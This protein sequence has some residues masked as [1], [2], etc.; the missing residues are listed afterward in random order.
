VSADDA[1]A[2]LWIDGLPGEVWA[3]D[4]DTWYEALAA[5]LDE[6]SPA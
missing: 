6:R 5:L 4:P 2:V 3:F 1:E